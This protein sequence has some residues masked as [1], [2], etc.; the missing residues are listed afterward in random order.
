MIMRCFLKVLKKSQSGWQVADC[1]IH[2]LRVW[3]DTKCPVL[4]VAQS[5][6]GWLMIADA[7]VRC[8]QRPSASLLADT[9]ARCDCDSR[10]RVVGILFTPGHSANAGPAAME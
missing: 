5:D 10:R 2:D 7:V 6:Y 9:P 1:S 3:D 8:C 4:Y